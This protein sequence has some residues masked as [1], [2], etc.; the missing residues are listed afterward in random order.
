MYYYMY[1][2]FIFFFVLINYLI[3]FGNY[4]M[5]KMLNVRSYLN[6]GNEIY[7]IICYIVNMLI[8]IMG[9]DI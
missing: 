3:I 6:V 2:W 7:R 9:L 5:I 1:K 8:L 4:K